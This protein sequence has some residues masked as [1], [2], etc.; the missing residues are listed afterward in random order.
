M[1]PQII[2]SL[3]SSRL[4][5]FLEA[6]QLVPDGQP[7]QTAGS[8]LAPVMHQNSPAMLKVALHAEEARGCTHMRLWQGCGVAPVLRH[9][10]GALLL[11]RAAKPGRM[12]ELARTGAPGDRDAMAAAVAVAK[13]LHRLATPTAHV[14]PLGQWFVALFRAAKYGGWWQECHQLAE[15]LLAGSHAPVP[16]H[17]DLH[18]GNILHFG[19]RGWL[20]IDPKGL[21]G[22]ATF[23]YVNLLCN[24]DLPESVRLGQF[25][26][27]LADLAGIA[28][29]DSRLLLAWVAAY[30]ALSAAWL[31]EDGQP[32]EPQK[33]MA[34]LALRGLTGAS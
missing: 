32:F 21:W 26:R 31:Q 20:A 15:Q 24:P 14:V 23:D 22:E 7:F 33:Q 5:W 17:G 16:L 29:V 1:R 11:E 8:L 3:N 2:P 34:Q 13:R 4:E 18:H 27:R 19:P 28:E 9:G 30:S 6:W 25:D 12:M 10:N